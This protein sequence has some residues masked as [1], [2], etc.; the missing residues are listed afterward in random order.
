MKSPNIG[1]LSNATCIALLLLI[2][3]CTTVP[4]TG[5]KSLHILPD[6]ELLSMSLQEYNDVLK[7]SKLSNDPAK[8]QMVK[9][10]GERIASATEQF[11]TEKGMKSEIKNYKW[12]FNLIEDDKVANA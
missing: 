3:G 8:V 6:S 7:K 4:V 2:V 11:F 10:V 5:R 12:E 9:R 1:Y